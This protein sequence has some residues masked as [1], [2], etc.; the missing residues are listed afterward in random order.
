MP[1]IAKSRDSRTELEKAGWGLH[2]EQVRVTY[3]TRLGNH[4]RAEECRLLAE[5]WQRRR[6]ELW[7]EAQTN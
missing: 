6:D 5:K 4:K 7:A 2:W 1:V 3:F